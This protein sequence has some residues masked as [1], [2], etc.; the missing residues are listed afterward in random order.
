MISSIIVG[1]LVGI[2][3]SAIVSAIFYSKG[4]RD[5]EAIYRKGQLDTVSLAMERCDPTQMRGRR[6]DDGLEPT[7]HWIGC[8]IG[9]V[10]R[11]GFLETARELRS[12]KED[13]DALIAAFSNTGEPE[14]YRRKEIWKNKVQNLYSRV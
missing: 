12:V 14:K 1:F 5:A 13:M 7:S 6:G 2:A 8:M 4:K 11:T 10:E 9:V 3:S